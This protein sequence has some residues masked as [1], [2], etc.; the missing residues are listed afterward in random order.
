MDFPELKK[1]ADSTTDEKIKEEITRLLPFL[2][3]VS[4]VDGVESSV[5]GVRSDFE[6]LERKLGHKLNSTFLYLYYEGGK[7]NRLEMW[8]N[9]GRSSANLD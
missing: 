8:G 3:V 4:F 2:E 5:N 1:L 7:P 6:S 9:K